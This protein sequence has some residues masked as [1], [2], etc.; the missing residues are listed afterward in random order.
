M[1]GGGYASALLGVGQLASYPILAH[2][3]VGELSKWIR[4]LIQMR[5]KGGSSAAAAPTPV[6]TEASSLLGALRAGPPK[7]PSASSLTSKS[8]PKSPPS[9]PGVT[10]G[11]PRSPPRS[12]DG[13]DGGQAP[14]SGSGGSLSN[15]VEHARG[16]A[17]R[18]V[19]ADTDGGDSPFADILGTAREAARRASSEEMAAAIATEIRVSDCIAGTLWVV[20]TTALAGLLPDVSSLLALT[21][22]TCATPLMTIFPPLMLARCERDDAIA[23]DFGGAPAEW[24]AARRRWWGPWV[25]HAFMCALGCFTTVVGCVIAFSEFGV[26]G[27]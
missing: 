15:L 6:P 13:D 19:K 3:A 17:Q 10:P 8:P 12:P 16:A 24:Q 2:A 7:V 26:E 21:G 11:P 22:A 14:R 5:L 20:L 23:E 27:M 25:V 18:L 1:P 9:P 4:V